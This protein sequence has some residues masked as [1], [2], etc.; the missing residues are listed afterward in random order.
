MAEPTFALARDDDAIR[1]AARKSTNASAKKLD[2]RRLEF[3]KKQILLESLMKKMQD[4]SSQIDKSSDSEEKAALAMERDRTYS[5]ASFLGISGLYEGAGIMMDMISVEMIHDKK[6]GTKTYSRRPLSDIMYDC[7]EA[8]EEVLGEQ[9]ITNELLS[10]FGKRLDATW[11]NKHQTEK[12]KEP[13]PEGPVDDAPG[14]TA[15]EIAAG[16]KVTDDDVKR[17][18]GKD[19]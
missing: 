4:L 2:A 17:A 11:K 5:L 1:R 13:P 10:D 15:E 18:L 19:K 3:A 8:L 9:R 7:F 6:D 12:P 14:L 16:T